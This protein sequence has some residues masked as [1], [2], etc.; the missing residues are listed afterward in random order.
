MYAI[1]SYYGYKNSGKNISMR[2]DES[3]L[4]SNL[5]IGDHTAFEMLFD[6]YADRLYQFS[7]KYLKSKEIAEDVV[8]EVFMTV[9]RNVITSYSIHYT[10]LYETNR[11]AKNYE[12]S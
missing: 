6:Q 11:P 8:Q 7:L 2:T 5:K 4:L 1:R 10:K 3:K 9:W 12:S